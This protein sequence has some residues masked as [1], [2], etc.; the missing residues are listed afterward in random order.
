[1]PDYETFRSSLTGAEIEDILVS[2]F[3]INGIVQGDGNGNM[4]Q[5]SA[6]DIASFIKALKFEAQSLTLE[7]KKTARTNIGATPAPIFASAAP[8]TSTEGEVNQLYFDTTEKKIYRLDSISGS[9]YNWALYG[10]SSGSALTFTDT[11]NGN[12][13]ISEAS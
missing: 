9:T 2:L 13:V 12:I 10:G 8:T 1:M 3:N 7:E 6:S 4:S 11:G 5:A